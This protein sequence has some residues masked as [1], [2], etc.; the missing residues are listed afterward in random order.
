MTATPPPDLSHLTDALLTAAR[1]AGADAADA[2]AVDGTAISID[3]RQGR[4]EA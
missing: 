1:K 3:V 2:I 4:L